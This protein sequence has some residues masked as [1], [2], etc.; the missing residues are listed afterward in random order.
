MLHIIFSN[1]IETK[2]KQIQDLIYS[3]LA[4][5]V[6]QHKTTENYI[7]N[8]HDE[9]AVEETLEKIYNTKWYLT[10]PMLVV[11]LVISAFFT[12]L[13]VFTSAL[14]LGYDL[15]TSAESCVEHK[16]VGTIV[17]SSL[18]ISIIVYLGLV[19]YAR[20]FCANTVI[21]YTREFAMDTAIF[22]CLSLLVSFCYIFGMI[23]SGPSKQA[24]LSVNMISPFIS[25]INV[26]LMLGNSVGL[27]VLESYVTSKYDQPA[28]D[29]FTS[30]DTTGKLR[31]NVDADKRNQLSRLSQVL[32]GTLSQD[33]LKTY[34]SYEYGGEFVMLWRLIDTY[35]NHQNALRPFQR[36]Q[37]L[38]YMYYVFKGSTYALPVKIP[39]LMGSPELDMGT[40]Y[41]IQMEVIELHLL[42]MYMRMSKLRRFEEQLFTLSE[43]GALPAIE[44]Y[45]LC[46]VEEP[47]KPKEEET[48]YS[49]GED[50]E[51]IVSALPGRHVNLPHAVSSEEPR[52]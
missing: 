38:K 20:Q 29:G 37:L 43:I 49:S 34:A 45:D 11:P 6:K 35:R 8:Y 47:T 50:E 5:S 14:I 26:T 3:E 30:T 13:Y 31:R 10:Y 18:T 36:K 46:S 41:D 16:S 1:N 23:T 22:I 12:M 32:K 25:L 40:L 51:D 48:S 24:V 2:K 15:V 33:L 9:D 7:I 44:A 27:P 17:M 42:P 39:T 28:N 52:R 21:A 19:C 4:K